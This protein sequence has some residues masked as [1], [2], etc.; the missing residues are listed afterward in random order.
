MPNRMKW[1]RSAGLL[2]LMC[3][4]F[5]SLQVSRVSASP[6]D[7]I[8]SV[9]SSRLVNVLPRG[10]HFFK[11][12]DIPYN[13]PILAEG[14]TSLVAFF[15]GINR[16]LIRITLT[17]IT[18][19]SA[20]VA[21]EV[22]A[23][24]YKAA[25]PGGASLVGSI[26]D[27]GGY[28]AIW[29]DSSHNWFLKATKGE[30]I[31]SVRVNTKL[32][33]GGVSNIANRLFP[34][35]YN[36]LSAT[37]AGR[38]TA[39]PPNPSPK[40]SGNDCNSPSPTLFGIPSSARN[41]PPGRVA[42]APVA[43]PRTVRPPARQPGVQPPRPAPAPAPAPK[44]TF[45]R[46]DQEAG[47]VGGEEKFYSPKVKAYIAK[48]RN[49]YRSYGIDQVAPYRLTVPACTNCAPLMVYCVTRVNGTADFRGKAIR[50][51]SDWG[52][53]FVRNAGGRPSRLPFSETRRGLQTGI[54]A[55]STSGAIVPR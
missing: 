48:V 7:A 38:Q 37:P 17:I 18:H 55:C 33:S 1:M 11:E 6:C 8:K 31:L 47:G 51:S 25:K 35:L 32:T 42:R 2:V 16:P 30:Y 14:C 23:R 3:S 5:Y 12:D 27:I 24:N 50:I 36:A 20:K 19:Q 10:Y 41:C 49:A 26:G 44:E 15:A 46:G 34:T 21:Q 54:I 13:V 45:D 28:S 39:F 29:N 43:Q 52:A 4:C 40:V 9:W 53:R 22:L